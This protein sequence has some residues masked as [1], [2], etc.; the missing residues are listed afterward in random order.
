MTATA[1]PV[2]PRLSAANRTA[3]VWPA[4]ALAAALAG[5]GPGDA[6]PGYFFFALDEGTPVTITLAGTQAPPDA[7]VSVRVHETILAA[8]GDQTLLGVALEALH[9]HP[10]WLAAIPGGEPVPPGATFSLAFRLSST[11]PQYGPSVDFTATFALVDERPDEPEETEIVIGSTR[12]GGGDLTVQYDFDEPIPLYFDQCL[13]GSG[14]DCAGG[15]VLYSSPN[16]G[17]APRE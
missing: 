10:E 11:A 7:S 12:N 14:D 9:T 4:L 3:P 1:L 8:P 2:P 17:F 15:V 5:C 6:P 13:G 16:P